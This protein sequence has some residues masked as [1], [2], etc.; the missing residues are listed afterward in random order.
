MRTSSY[1]LVQLLLD[2][3]ISDVPLSVYRRARYIPFGLTGSDLPAGWR[4]KR[5]SA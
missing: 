4:H 2:W 1:A 3:L 5:R